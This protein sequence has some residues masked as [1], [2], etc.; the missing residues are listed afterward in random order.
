MGLIDSL[1]SIWPCPKSNRLPIHLVPDQ[2][3]LFYH[4]ILLKVHRFCLKTESIHDPTIHKKHLATR[5]CFQVECPSTLQFAWHFWSHW[6]PQVDLCGS[7]SLD[8]TIH[9]T[10][11]SYTSISCGTSVLAGAFSDFL[12][13]SQTCPSSSIR[14]PGSSL[15]PFL[16]ILFLTL[17]W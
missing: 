9:C 10:W 2:E 14:A 11:W 5:Q 6:P 1:H 16:S 17:L 8:Y 13:H 7:R 4:S 15:Q 3:Y 12:I